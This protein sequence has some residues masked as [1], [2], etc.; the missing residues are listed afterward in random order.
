[1]PT[2]AD[3]EAFLDRIEPDEHVYHDQDPATWLRQAA[4]LH[5]R[6]ESHPPTA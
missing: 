3:V 2:G 5:R 4:E 6:E 1:V